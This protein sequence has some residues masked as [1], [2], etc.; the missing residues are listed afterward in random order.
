MADL[1]ALDLLLRLA[2]GDLAD[3]LP[4]RPEWHKQAACRG[5]GSDAFYPERGES[6]KAARALCD[7][8][9][10]RQP[11]HEAG[12]SEYEGIWAGTSAR[13]RAALR[14]SAA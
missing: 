12:L 1:S 4:P 7:R 9:T 14:R 11:C 2:P 5:V 8:C 3:L 13:A 10:V 6:T